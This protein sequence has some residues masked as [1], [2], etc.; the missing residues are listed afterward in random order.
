MRLESDEAFN[1]DRTTDAPHLALRSAFANRILHF[2]RHN[3]LLHLPGKSRAASGGG[4]DH[5]A[6]RSG[7]ARVATSS[8][9]CAVS[10]SRLLAIRELGSSKRPCATRPRRTQTG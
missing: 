5:T 10:G 3:K 2:L 6:G 9:E 7:A 8:V 4:T 1:P